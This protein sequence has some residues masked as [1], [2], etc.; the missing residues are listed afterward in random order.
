MAA[1]AALSEGIIERELGSLIRGLRRAPG[2]VPERD[3]LGQ[4]ASMRRWA[5]QHLGVR[6][7]GMWLAERVWEPHLPK[8]LHEAG[9]RY[10]IL[11]DTH[12]KYGG[13][14]DD[15]LDLVMQVRGQARVVDQAGLA[16]GHRHHGVGRFHEEE[17]RLAAGEA[18]LPGVLL[19][20]AADAV[21][22]VHRKAFGAAT[23]GEL[24][25]DER[26]ERELDAD[27]EHLARRGAGHLHRRLPVR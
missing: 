22:A 24:L 26:L 18:H 12:F 5:Q 17:R 25:V 2:S 10:T 23:D 6:P 15:E 8:V 3:A 11:D 19:V 20:V 14:L 13:Y 16:F 9:L 1:L 4:I 27:D 7:D 21:D